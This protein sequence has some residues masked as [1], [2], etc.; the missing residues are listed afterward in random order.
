MQEEIDKLVGRDVWKLDGVR[1][2]ADVAK[3]AKGTTIQNPHG[4]CLR[5]LRRKGLRDA[6]GS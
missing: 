1:Q 5:H 6:Q 3:E 4:Q 2:W